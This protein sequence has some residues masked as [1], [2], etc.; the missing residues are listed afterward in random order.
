MAGRRRRFGHVRKLPSGRYQASYLDPDAV[1][2]SA[3]E[4]F[5]TKRDAERWLS[6][7]ETEL[8]QGQW[9]DPDLRRQT[10]GDFGA[11]WI[12]ERPGLRPRT[13]DLYRSLFRLH[14]VPDLGRVT[15]EDLDPAR[16]RRW[17]ADRL[18]S[19][20]SAVTT[21]KAYRLLRAILMTAVD[22]GVIASNPCRIRG[23]GSEPTPERP[24]LTV[25]QV[26]ELAERM[27]TE[28]Y[29]L[30]VL[31][32]TFASLRWGEVT[33]LRRRDVDADT[34][35]VWVRSAFGRSYSGPVQR[36]AP[37][38]RAGLR[39]VTVPVPVAERL[40]LHLA[41]SVGEDPE[42]LVFTGD[43]GGPLQRNNFNK[44]VDWARLVGEVGVPGLHFHD[45]RHT[46]NTF[47]AMTG[48]SLRDLMTRMGHD[49]MRAALI[50]QHNTQG[51]DRK[52]ADA[53]GALIDQHRAGPVAKNAGSHGSANRTRIARGGQ[54]GSSGRATARSAGA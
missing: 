31:M 19:G 22:D 34:G 27:P 43:K 12:S 38:S 40:A 20:V 18:E 17:R 26:F 46:G 53:M 48:A 15:L 7:V 50:Y 1:R 51:A 23:A 6:V 10:L 9:R 32:T 30:L 33:A 21:A 37:K 52:I 14:V 4:T 24:V 28:S 13:A 25:A 49:S 3:Q 29:A 11:R 39:Q 36:G 42:A 41:A 45:L 54:D 8:L 16:V 44:R 5:T 2:R 47:A 35:A